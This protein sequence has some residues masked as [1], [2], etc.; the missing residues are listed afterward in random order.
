MRYMTLT[1]FH[2]TKISFYVFVW[3]KIEKKD[4]DL[5]KYSFKKRERETATAKSLQSC[6][7]LC[8]PTDGSPPGFPVPGI[9]QARTLEWV[10]ISFSSAWKWKVKVKLLSRVRPSATPWTAAFQALLS[11]EFSRQEYWSGVPLPSPERET[12]GTLFY[13]TWGIY[14][15]RKVS[16]DQSYFHILMNWSILTR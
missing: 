16:M 12:N 4:T 11:M 2:S 1:H 6:P 9:L 14:F 3:K 5:E 10:A 15:G 8:D 13:R 7:T